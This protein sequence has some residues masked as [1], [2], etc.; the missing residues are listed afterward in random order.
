MEID[1]LVD[2]PPDLAIEIDITSSSLDRLEIYAKLRIPEIWRSDGQSLEI[3][4]LQ[5]DGAYRA[6]PTSLCLPQLPVAE[7]VR[8][9]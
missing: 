3:L 5:P 9:L 7:L 2:H 4:V 6:S 1:L 8:F